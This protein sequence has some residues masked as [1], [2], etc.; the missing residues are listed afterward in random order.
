MPVRSDDRINPG[1]LMDEID[2]YPVHT[3][4]YEN[5]VV[6]RERSLD[7]V[8]EQDLD[9]AMFAAPEGYRRQDPFGQR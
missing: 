1:E 6:A 7:A 2:G 9:Q 8:N 4:D 5:G 3:I